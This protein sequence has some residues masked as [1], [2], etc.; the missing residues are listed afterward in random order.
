MTESSVE[1]ITNGFNW[2]PWVSVVVILFL[3]LWFILEIRNPRSKKVVIRVNVLF[4]MSMSYGV[5]LT[6][7]L[8][9]VLGPGKMT[10]ETAWNILEAPIMALI[11]GTLA[12]SKDLIQDD[13]NPDSS[14]GT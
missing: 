2:I 12:I 5:I 11:G 6:I 4:L 8:F 13:D 1:S 9:L 7:F 10:A 14:K 3:T